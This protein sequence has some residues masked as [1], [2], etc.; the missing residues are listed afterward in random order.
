MTTFLVPK[1]GR[2]FQ[3]LYSARPT[4]VLVTAS[5]HYCGVMEG[6]LISPSIVLHEHS[7]VEVGGANLLGKCDTN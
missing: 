2:P 1:S 7:S 6:R 3:M 4:L 5:Y